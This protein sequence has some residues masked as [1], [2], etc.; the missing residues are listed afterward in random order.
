MTSRR[1]SAAHV[2]VPDLGQAEMSDE[3][4]H[5]LAK[6]LR[7]RVGE[8]VTVSDGVGTWQWHRITDA[9]MGLAPLDAP[10]RE[11]RPRPEIGVAFAVTKGDRPEWTVQKLTEVGVDH[12]WPLVSERTVV[13]WDEAKMNRNRERLEKVAREAAM[14]SRS[15]FLPHVHLVSPSV[16][17]LVDAVAARGLP[18]AMAVAEPGA[19]AIDADV[20][21]VLIGP[22]GG[23]TDDE[24]GLV[25][26]RVSLPGGILRAETAAI[27]AGVLLA[28][29]RRH[30]GG[31]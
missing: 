20:T 15:V 19:A 23:F 28:E 3:D 6:V 30:R 8:T 17:S 1:F 21:V 5:H 29:G 4:R 2:F 7:L 14:Q 13:R 26:R 11:M 22:E 24:S 25:A 12:I 10:V 31:T 9:D 16:A 27:A 18:G